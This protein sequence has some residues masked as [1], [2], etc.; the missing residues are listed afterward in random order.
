MTSF[1]GSRQSGPIACL[2]LTRAGSAGVW[3]ASGTPPF[4][5]PDPLAPRI[6]NGTARYPPWGGMGFGVNVSR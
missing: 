3:H 6:E 5:E 4:G 1:G 2:M